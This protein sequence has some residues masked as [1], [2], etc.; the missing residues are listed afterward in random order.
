VLNEGGLL[1]ASDVSLNTHYRFDN[2][3]V[4]P[5]N[6]LA[7]EAAFAIARDQQINLNLLYLCAQPGM[8]KTHLARAVA[9]EA[10]RRLGGGVRYTSAEAFTNEFLGALRHRK[11]GEFKRH[12]RRGCRLL[13]VENV[14]FLES[15]NATQLEFF[16]TV[17]HV[18]DAGGRVVL[19]GASMPQDLKELDARVRSQLASG[20]VAEIE[21][22]DAQVRRAILRTKAAHGGLHIPT[23]CLD[24]LVDS[25]RGSVREVESV[26]IQ[27]VTT[28]ALLKHP[29]DLTLT[30]SAIAKKTT[31]AKVD[32]D[33]QLDVVEV[34]RAVASFFQTTPERL[35][36]R[37]R[38]K[39]ILVPRQLAIYLCH[40]YTSAS[41]SQIGE[42]V[43]RDQPAVRNAIRKI[44]RGILERAPLRYQVEALCGHLGRGGHGGTTSA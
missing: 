10:E 18:L 27:L 16:H 11:T 39:E 30:R 23:A 3:V 31:T 35:A 40:R 28:A 33:R 2:F 9:T 26:L 37:S 22:P 24:L 20:F 5:C 6:A 7:R 38:R 44:E 14:Q 17:Q 8:G 19:T 13:V 42:A 4:G 32:E 12:Y 29:I 43:G 25:V 21:A 41:I 1:V 15:K 36:S 34:I